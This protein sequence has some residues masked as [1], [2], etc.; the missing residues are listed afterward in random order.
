MLARHPGERAWR[1]ERVE[2]HSRV[3]YG[4]YI[5]IGTDDCVRRP[6]EDVTSTQL[7]APRRT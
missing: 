2:S 4:A 3:E 5:C 1:V 7:A 6:S